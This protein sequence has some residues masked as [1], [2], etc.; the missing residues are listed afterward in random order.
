[1]HECTIAYC[2]FEIKGKMNKYN[3]KLIKINKREKEYTG[4]LEI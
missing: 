3:K 4:Y 2:I 1:M